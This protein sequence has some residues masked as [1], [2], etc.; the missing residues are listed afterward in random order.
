V[1][2]AKLEAARLIPT[3]DIEMRTLLSVV[4]MSLSGIHVDADAWKRVAEQV[5]R[6]RDAALERLNR[7]VDPP[8]N[9]G[10]WKWV[11]E[12]FAQHGVVVKDTKLKTFEAYLSHHPD[13]EFVA[14]YI[15]YAKVKHFA[16]NWAPEFV[17]DHVDAATGRFYPVYKQHGAVTGRMTTAAPSVQQ[18][19]NTPV[20][21]G[22]FTAPEG[23]ALVGA[24]YSQLE[25]RTVAQISQDRAMIK[26]FADGVDLHVES[27]K[28]LLDLDREP[29]R[30]ERKLGK[31][32]NFGPIYGQS[33]KGLAAKVTSEGQPTT[34]VEAE[35]YLKKLFQKYPQ[36][37]AWYYT[38][39]NSRSTE[40]R[41]LLGRR[42]VNA[43]KQQRLN[44]PNQASGADI[45]KLAMARL[46]E[47]RAAV[48]GVK[49]VLSC[50]DELLLEV[51]LAYA[52]QA[53]EWLVQ[54]ME[55]AA[56]AVLPDVSVEVDA[57]I[58]RDWAKTPLVEEE[59]MSGV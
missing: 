54:H 33:P 4:W 41:S 37:G 3:I 31:A 57:Y 40:I 58:A 36:L 7:F 52:E 59:P 18:I 21:R 55:A 9:W 8:T 46:Y 29:T 47:D 43:S 13:N 53:K 48:P 49:L 14:S 45:L 6:D 12:I 42:R 34:E 30:E 27:A 15:D 2:R 17:K 28:L 5:L 25:L 19:P 32:F 35:R 16:S 50:H 39:K 38:T 56:K 44:Y 26:A 22:F 51:D 11:L 20:Y 23:K 10:S 1:L 24:D